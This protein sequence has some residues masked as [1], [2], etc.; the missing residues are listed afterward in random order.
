MIQ[1]FEISGY[2]KDNKEEFEGF[3]VTNLDNPTEEGLYQEEDIFFY[4]LGEKDLE[5][6]LNNEDTI[7]D[8]VI[9]NYTEI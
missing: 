7:H 3:I 6:A 9:T 4:G 8:F 1:F 2:W 5:D